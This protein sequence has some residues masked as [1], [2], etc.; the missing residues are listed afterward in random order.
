MLCENCGKREANVRYTENIN[1]RR[2]ELNL[3]EECSQKLGVGQMDFSMPIDFSSF[4]GGFM[5]ELTTP[6]FMPMLNTLKQ[7]KCNNCGSTFDD[8]MN[9]GMLGCQD[10]YNTFD[11][12]L[13]SIIKKLQGSN[14]HVGRIGKIIDK[15]IDEKEGKESKK[16]DLKNETNNKTKEDKKIL[17]KRDLEQAIK[18]ERYE[19]AAKIRDEIKALEK[20]DN[21]NKKDDKSE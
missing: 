13:D 20:T 2:R 12:E 9:T 18:E 3:C 17:L 5:D 11:D 21:K 15:K 10:C 16:T 19:D 4:L 7:N 14:R 1:G 6:S 8:I